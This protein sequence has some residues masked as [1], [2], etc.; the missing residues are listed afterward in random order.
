MAKSFTLTIQDDAK[1]DYIIE[2]FMQGKMWTTGVTNPSFDDQLPEHPIDNP[3][4]IPNPVTKS[5]FIKAWIITKLREEATIGHTAM[6]NQLEYEEI[7]NNI[8]ID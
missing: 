4:E 5:M 3:M 7:F 2:G 8:V 6:K 1:A